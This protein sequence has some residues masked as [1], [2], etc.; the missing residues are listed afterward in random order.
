MS[1]RSWLR[2]GLV[3]LVVTETATGAWQYF[4][5]K[6]F[7]AYFPTVSLDPPFNEHLM[8]DVGGLNLGMTVVV[9]FAAVYMEYRL[10]CGALSGYTVFA[11]SHLI[12]HA[13]HSDRFTTSDAINVV[14]GL[15]VYAVIPVA[16]ILLARRTQKAKEPEQPAR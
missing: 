14:T 8:S 2:L 16:L 11:I 12:F 13:S 7:F 4:F 5:S 3:F 15:A 10:I 9:A 1:A 6:S